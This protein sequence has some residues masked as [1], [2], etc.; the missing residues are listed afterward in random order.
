[1]IVEMG[2]L[3]FDGQVYHEQLLSSFKAL[4]ER[5]QDFTDS[6]YTKHE[7][8]EKI[9][10]L[11]DQAKLQLNQVIQFDS[12]IVSVKFPLMNAPKS[13]FFN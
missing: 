11:A 7:H 5:T 6:A 12:C 1:M 13:C 4:I 10:L 2:R 8:R 9:L 3:R